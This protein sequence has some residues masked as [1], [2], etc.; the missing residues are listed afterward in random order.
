MSYAGTILQIYALLKAGGSEAAQQK[1]ISII[2]SA[3]TT[4]MSSASISYV[5]ANEASSEEEPGARGRPKGH[6][7]N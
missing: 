4:G 1:V 3:L 5:R 2:I 6:R 7:P